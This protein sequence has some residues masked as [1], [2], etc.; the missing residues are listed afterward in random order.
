MNPART[1]AWI[2]LFI[3]CGIA[4]IPAIGILAWLIG[5]P[6]LLVT[7]ILSIVI[8]STGKSGG[9]PLL[10]FTLIVAPAIIVGAPIVSTIWLGAKMEKSREAEASALVSAAEKEG[11]PLK[12]TEVQA[13]QRAI[14]LYP[15]LG[16]AGSRMNIA[17]RDRVD[18]YRRSQPALFNDSE[19]PLLV[20]KEVAQSVR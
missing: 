5:G 10:F 2:L 15:Q 8:M 19:W 13:R 1:S 12:L 16:I 18:S 4:C 17:F 6:V 11:Q 9:I 3:V 7:F 20:A 14:R